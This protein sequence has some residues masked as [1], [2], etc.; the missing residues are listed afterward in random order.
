VGGDAAPVG[1]QFPGVVE[2]DDT[3]AEQPP[4]LFGVGGHE[5]GGLMIRS[6][7]GGACRLVLTHI[8]TF[9]L[10]GSGDLFIQYPSMPPASFGRD[11]INPP[12]GTY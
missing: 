2:D 4:A 7:R 6:V 11:G 5:L 1:E 8:D 9:D 3:V 12:I 10:A